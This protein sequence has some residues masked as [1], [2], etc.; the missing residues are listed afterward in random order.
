M[1]LKQWS[2]INTLSAFLYFVVTQLGQFSGGYAIITVIVF[3]LGVITQLIM[4][5]LT[6]PAIITAEYVFILSARGIL[7]LIF[8][9]LNTFAIAISCFF[10]ICV[11]DYQQSLL[12]HNKELDNELT[13]DDIKN[14]SLFSKTVLFCGLFVG[15]LI[16][17]DII[18]SI[19]IICV[20]LI[21]IIKQ[22]N[23]RFKTI[24]FIELLITILWRVGIYYQLVAYS[25]QELITVFLCFAV[26][27]I[28]FNFIKNSEN[29]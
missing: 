4:A 2:Y 18:T 11:L 6:R 15:M 19:I 21:G 17:E 7:F 14:T 27:I 22:N 16:T 13:E 24:I 26:F 28:N 9:L 5:G 29:G 20:A 3:G 8:P 1:S 25:L 12:P 10:A 23:F